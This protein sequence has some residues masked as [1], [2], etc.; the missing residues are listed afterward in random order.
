MKGSTAA[1]WFL[2]ILS[3]VIAVFAFTAEPAVASQ[4]LPATTTDRAGVSEQ[5]LLL[6]DGRTVLC[7]I[8][9]SP[10]AVSCDWNR[11]FLP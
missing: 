2:G 10:V 11:A 3:F 4:E 5:R 6:R 9:S 1:L 8:F 7:L